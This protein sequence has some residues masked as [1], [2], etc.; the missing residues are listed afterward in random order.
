MQPHLLELQGNKWRGCNREAIPT[1]ALLIPAGMDAVGSKLYRRFRETFAV[2]VQECNVRLVYV[3]CI[4]AYVYCIHTYIHTAYNG[5][6][7]VS[8]MNGDEG[9][10]PKLADP[11]TA[12]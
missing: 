2:S 7:C 12:E 10:P 3:Y 9:C 5:V 11:L 1:S 6:S 4:S 8:T